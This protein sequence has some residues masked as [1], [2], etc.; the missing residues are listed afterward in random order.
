ML[1]MFGKALLI[2]AFAFV[3]SLIA[4]ALVRSSNQHPNLE[5]SEKRE[6]P[7]EQGT[8]RNESWEAVW[9]RTKHDPVAL[10]TAVL[11]ISTAALFI[12]GLL[13]IGF[14][15][16]ADYTAQSAAEA[17]KDA[18]NTSREALVKSQRAFVRSVGFP[19]F[20]RPDIDRVGRDFYDI[21]PNIENAGATPTVDMKIVVNYALRNTPL[22]DDFDFPYVIE[23]GDSI[24][25]PHQIIGTNNALIVDDDLVSVQNG[26]KFFYMWGTIT[27]RD[28]FDRTPVHITE[29]CT[30]ITRVL[31]NPLDPRDLAIGPRATSVEITF[32][33]YKN[34][35]KIT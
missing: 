18:A 10:F 4:I 17:A 12:L 20:W 29:Y 22:P 9:Q 34:H 33:M 3:V 15:I 16:R 1:N 32:G 2:A 13:Q 21:T 26:T 23:P 11:A 27:Y 7:T 30:Q 25:G 19:W 31:G 14:F 8:I 6:A 35:N 28:V 24:I 5:Y